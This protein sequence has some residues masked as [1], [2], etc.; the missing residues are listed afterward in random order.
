MKIQ[1]FLIG[2][3]PTFQTIANPFAAPAEDSSSSSSSKSEKKSGLISDTLLNKLYETG[4]PVDVDN[5]VER[6]SEYEKREQW[7]LGVSSSAIRGLE[8][9]ANRIIQQAKYLDRAEKFAEAN[10][11]IGEIAVGSK[12]QLYTRDE[13]N[14][15]QT[16]AMSQYDPEKHGYALTVGD[17]IEQR[18]FNPDKA[19][20]TD[21]TQTINNNLGMSKIN[22]YILG[23]IKTV[24]S[25]ST[26]SEAYTDLASYI[27]KEAAKRPTEAELKNL[28]NLAEVLQKLGPDAIFKNKQIMESK[29]ITEA[30]NYIQSVLPRD[31]QL[32]LTGRFVAN[33][34]NLQQSGNYMKSIIAQ[35]LDSANKTVT[36]NYL[37]YDASINKAAGTQAG[38]K[39]QNKNLKAIEVLTQ[40]SLNKVDYNITSRDN[41]NLSMTLHGTVSGALT[42]Y[43]NNI[44][45]KSPISTA[46]ESS[47]GPLV[48]KQHVTMGSQ[49]I[50][51]SM[52]DT[53][54]YDGNDVI[55]IW[56]PTDQNGDI[57]LSGLQTFNELL[58]YFDSDPALSISDKNNILNQYGIQGYLN[59]NGQ[60]VG[61]GNMAQF[62]VFTGITSDEVLNKKDPFVD[63]LDSEN[64]KY[65]LEQ[66]ERVYGYLNG[67]KR[68]KAGNLEFKKGWFDFTTDILK[69]PV[70]MKLR[71]TAKTEVSTFA[72]HGP[73]VSMPSYEE[74]VTRDQL[75][76]NK[77]HSPQVYQPSTS[78]LYGE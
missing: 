38:A 20:D 60:F 65:E 75:R 10:N 63:T 8:A 71:P 67:Q 2:G 33:G 59:E 1:K 9:T 25:S 27:G 68:N 23:I 53:I 48:D 58:S 44:I 21:L 26:T 36:G 17:L 40:G 39:E 15:I 3:S 28:Q 6:L 62:L 73:L 43:D 70:F 11:A 22:D 19:Y 4:I 16:V 57:D 13:N 76:Y 64:K 69:A 5:F 42:N 24:G 66:I 55:N 45:P 61:N 51:E 7:G 31:M 56:A 34:G 30:F 50:Q 74:L 41:P 32:Q 12:G 46:I 78:L 54:L 77:E 29:N 49:K 72:N 47:I 37:D 14:K 52:F 35:A 18:K